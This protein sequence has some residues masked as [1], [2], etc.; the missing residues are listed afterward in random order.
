MDFKELLVINGNVD[1][2]LHHFSDTVQLLIG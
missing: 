2:I 1:P